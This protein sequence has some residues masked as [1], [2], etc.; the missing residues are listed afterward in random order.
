M[1]G[2]IQCTQPLL[3]EKDSIV[4]DDD[5]W[6]GLDALVM[7]DSHI[8]QGAVVA[9]RAVVKGNIEPYSI[10]GGIPA[11]TI[12]MRFS[13]SIV[14][15]LMECDFSKITQ[16]MIN[17]HFNELNQPLNSVSQIEWIPRKVRQ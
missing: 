5:V 7:S 11:K 6:I 4:L 10:V 3:K 9:A 13:D 2:T 14:S 8:G 1:G 16:E 17:E 12:K 15:E